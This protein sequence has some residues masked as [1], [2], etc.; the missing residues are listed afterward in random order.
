MKLALC[1]MKKVCQF[2]ENAA[3]VDLSA[4]KGP[5]LMILITLLIL[6]SRQNLVRLDHFVLEVLLL[7]LQQAGYQASKW[8][9]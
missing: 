6:G 3:P 2:L 4:K 8:A 5:P 7:I 1:A 9:R